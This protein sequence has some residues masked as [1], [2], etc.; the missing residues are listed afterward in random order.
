MRVEWLNPSRTRALL[1]R[2][3]WWWK[4]V[5]TVEFLLYNN[6]RCID[7]GWHYVNGPT[8]D[9][10]LRKLVSAADV[11]AKELEEE[12]KEAAQWVKLGKIPEARLLRAPQE[13][14]SPGNVR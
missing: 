10:G 13:Q 5:A 11:R 3:F 8:L 14:K 1:V 4:K 2:G 7:P 9:N 6:P 12:G